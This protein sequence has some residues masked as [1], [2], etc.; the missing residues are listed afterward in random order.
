MIRIVP[1]ETPT[2]DLHQ[3]LLGSVAPRPI[4]FVSTQHSNGQVN[5]APYSFFNVFSSNP[6]LAIFSANRR[7]TDKTEKDTL[8]NIQKT[9][10]CVIN[11][12]N[13]NMAHQMSIA[14]VEFDP[15]INEFQKSGLTP[16]TSELVAPP[17]VKESPV[18]L[19]CKVVDIQSMGDHKGGANLI[20][21]EIVL[22]HIQEDVVD[23]RSRILPDKI[24]LM[25]R[26]GR[27]YYIRAQG[28]NVKT[29]FQPILD[30]VIG[31]DRIPQHILQ[32]EKFN[33]KELSA[34]AALKVLPN[35]KDF[36]ELLNVNESLD[37]DQ[38]IVLIKEKINDGDAS[39]AMALSLWANAFKI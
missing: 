33:G 10:E 31:F 4:A 32:S 37:K 7:V 26:M 19:E 29:I 13:Y 27:S 2:R 9:K 6:P 8:I 11:M 17:R 21:C 25:G 36:T 30:P 3:L 24:D 20:F 38:L 28:E 22:M 35:M 5:L 23:E 16:L 39:E 12:V 34:L 14:S 15:S 18:Q 1:S